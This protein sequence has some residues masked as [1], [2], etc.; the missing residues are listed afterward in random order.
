MR[1]FSVFDARSLI[2]LPALTKPN[3]TVYKFLWKCIKSRG[4]KIT[5]NDQIVEISD[6]KAHFIDLKHF[7]LKTSKFNIF[8][9]IYSSHKTIKWKY[10]CVYSTNL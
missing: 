4:I 5:I 6:L 2:V 1:R 7:I 10:K 8:S 3:L 9:V